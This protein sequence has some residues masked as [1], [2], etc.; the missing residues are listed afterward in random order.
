M[1]G[2]RLPAWLTGL[3]KLPFFILAISVMIPYYWMATNAFKPIPEI[4]HNPPTWWIHTFTFDNFYNPDANIKNS[5]K[6]DEF[7]GIFQIF[8][9]T[10]FMHFYMNSVF[11][12]VLVV[13]TS[14]LI[15]SLVAYV[16]VKHPFPG[17]NVLFFLLLGS[18]M[19][20]WEVTIIPNF[21]TMTDLHWQSSYQALIFPGLA[22]AFA[23]FFFRQVIQSI[24]NELIDAARIDGAGELRIWWSVVLPI[25]RPALAAIAI[26]VMLG[27]WNNY[28]WPLLVVDDDAHQTLPLALGK[29]AGN[30]TYD[31]RAAGPLMA[32]SL[33]V[34]LPMVAIFLAFQRQFVQG[35]TSGATKG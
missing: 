12:T 22:K 14:L 4:V 5:G 27:E 35:L 21:L 30:L 13:V 18:M 26:P 33:L 28:L 16:L 6:T 3:L 20:P 34:S 25:V 15:A 10:G 29:L 32:A 23:V 17:S 8:A 2:E 7:Q 24:P 9:N 11:I 1:V 19:I 31:P